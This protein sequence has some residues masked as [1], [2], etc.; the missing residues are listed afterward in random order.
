MVLLRLADRQGL[1][2]GPA[3][4]R[5]QQWALAYLIVEERK[6]Q[7]DSVYDQQ[8]FMFSLIQPEL[9]REKIRSRPERDLADGEMNITP[10]DFSMVE[11]WLREL[12]KPK[13]TNLKG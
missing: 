8:E 9:Y 4:S 3:I 10:D 5:F 2:K 13:Q 6:E 7:S 1:F 12:D 11:K